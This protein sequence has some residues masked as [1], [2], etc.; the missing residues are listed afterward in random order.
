MTASPQDLV[1][2]APGGPRRLS[3]DDLLGAEDAERTEREANAWIKSIRNLRV[4]GVPFRDRFTLRGDSL[5]WFAELFLHKQ[6]V[7]A[8][9]FRSIAAFESLAR[10]GGRARWH[11]T[12]R[13]PVVRRVAGLVAARHRCECRLEGRADPVRGRQRIRAA[14][15][16]ASAL[17][18]RLR[19]PAI[20]RAAM[21]PTVAAFLHSAFF[22][23][24]TGDET[25]TGP[26][27]EALQAQLP[28][29]ALQVVGLGPRTNFRVRRLRDRLREFTDPAAA[30]LPFTPIESFAGWRALGPSMRVWRDRR[31]AFR[32]LQQSQDLRA[33]A[34]IDGY[35]VWPVLEAEIE[36]IALLQFP[37]SARAMD[38]AGA[39]LDRL[40]PAVVLTY[41][42][43]GGWGRALVLEARRREIPSVA[44]Q[45][46]FIYR[47]W[48]NY[49]HE[50]DEMRPS[51]GNPDDRGF[52]APTRTL[53]FDR[54]TARHL[55]SH[56]RFPEAALTVVGSPRLDALVASSG[57]RAGREAT[58]AKLGIVP[59]GRWDR[60][61]LIASKY[62]QIASVYPEI[63]GAAA[64]LPRVRL[65]V[66]PHP[67]EGSAPYSAAA[68]G[69]A[70]VVVVADGSPTL[71]ELLAA[72]DLLITVNSTA[73]VEAIVFDVPTLVVGLPNNLSPLVD[74]G[75]VAGAHD[76]RAAGR[77]MEALLYDGMM[78]EQ[79]SASRRA[80][81]AEFGIGADG[82][83]ARRAAGAVL[84]LAAAHIGSS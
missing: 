35:D 11:V 43:A 23:R 4:D 38:E 39:A 68:A 59:D 63:L 51:A 80:Y 60:L 50:P 73:A 52:P 75:A 15:F 2:Q 58:R 66:K 62:A 46:G 47:H 81:A 45:H 76:R 24:T 44:L 40:R 27:L 33:A 64:R 21:R 82:Q 3:V 17:A 26:V 30:G 72:A 10:E 79:L 49:L 61:V 19:R 56:G 34:T 57:G 9:V 6:R 32:S 65:V 31:T 29:G 71:A 48:L 18:D 16:T 1:V 25:Y 54:L 55:T 22:D 28:D 37:W 13:D 36:G 12:T 14:A 7:I 84:E 70:E 83:A 8:R 20:D 69:V 78:C 77:L 5:W 67:A 41:A 42:E 53:V 74:A